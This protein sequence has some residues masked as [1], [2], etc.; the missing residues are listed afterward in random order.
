MLPCYSEPYAFECCWWKLMTLNCRS[1]NTPRELSNLRLHQ[2]QIILRPRVILISCW[3]SS[4]NCA[5]FDKQTQ[6][7]ARS[8]T[9]EPL[10]VVGGHCVTVRYEQIYL[11]PHIQSDWTSDDTTNDKIAFPSN[12]QNP[13][14]SLATRKRKQLCETSQMLHRRVN[15]LRR[16]HRQLSV[17]SS[18]RLVSEGGQLLRLQPTEYR[19]DLESFASAYSEFVQTAVVCVERV[20]TVAAYG[21]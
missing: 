17:V 5:T 11:Y 14:F 15:W 4:V 3:C 10:S 13:K 7:L 8:G 19:S 21:R 16:P 18:V 2:F 20:W 1:V 9:D 6:S 12:W